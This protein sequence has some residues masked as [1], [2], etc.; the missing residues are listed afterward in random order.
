[1]KS[2]QSKN[3][4]EDFLLA[5]YS[6]IANAHFKSIDTV[7]TFFRYYLFIIAIPIYAI[8]LGIQFS[9]N[10]NEVLTLLE[11]HKIL[12]GTILLIFALGGLGLFIYIVNIRLDVIL[13]AR[14]INAVRKYFYDNSEL[15][16]I[17]KLKM[18]VLPQSPFTP[19]YYESRYF[20]PVVLTFAITNTF[21]F[22]VAKKFLCEEVSLQH[23]LFNS[24]TGYDIVFIVLSIVLHPLIYKEHSQYRE[25]SYLKENIIGIDIDGVLNKHREH[26]CKL[27]KEITGK[28][29]KA[30]EIKI[31]PVHENPSLNITEEEARKIFNTPKYWTEMPEVEYISVIRKLRNIFKLKIFIFTHRARPDASKREEKKK[32]LDSF[33]EEIK[34]KY[35]LSLWEKISL[36][37]SSPI[38]IITKKWL[39]EKN[40]PYD[41]IF[42]E[43]GNVYSSDSNILFKNR[44]YISSQKNIRFFVEDDIEKAIKLSFIC[45]VVF[46][47]SQPYNEYYDDLPEK[48]KE[49]R[50]NQNLLPNIIRVKDWDEIY[51]YIRRFI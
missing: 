24:I 20:I 33:Q 9:S 32:L 31:V 47:I 39:K 49:I 7:S 1:M 34:K 43:K 14:V 23:G 12:I 18:R 25:R 21:Y 40:I 41:K 50:K 13:Y 51:R 22:F 45:D 27:L 28:E 10:F 16:L 42:F 37:W 19:P 17:T 30:D 29:I 11:K 5:E 44:F 8:F 26:F 46:L 15:N 2:S 36:P 4:F 6:N 38:E 35:K 48:Y 3:R